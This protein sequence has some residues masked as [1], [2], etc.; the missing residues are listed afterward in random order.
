ETQAFAGNE[1][2]R[3]KGDGIEFIDVRPFAFGDRVRRVNWRLSTRRRE[4]YVNEFHRER[5]ADVIIFLDTFA[6]A[7]LRDEGTLNQ[8]VR[9]AATLAQ[10]YL[11]RGDRVGLVGFG[12]LLRWLRPASGVMQRYRIVESLID[13]EVV[14]S[15]AWKEINVIPPT[16][17]PPKA[18]VVAITPL[19]DERTINALL[20]LRARRF[21]LVV[22]EVSPVPFVSP[23]RGGTAGLALQIWKLERELLRDRFR[24]LGIPVGVWEVNRP[25]EGVVQEVQTF[26]RSAH[27]AHV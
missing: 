9:G 4:L 14:V 13:S 20:D 1:L 21:D 24:R 5:N 3:A 2:S 18:L 15:F 19:L 10:Y 22:I 23:P 27:R 8:A 17:L 11:D 25:L 26:R 7:R 6:E 12:G 16:T